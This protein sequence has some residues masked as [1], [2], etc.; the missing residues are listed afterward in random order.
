MNCYPPENT[1]RN[2]Q[3]DWEDH[4]YLPGS[5]D[6]EEIRSRRRRSCLNGDMQSPENMEKSLESIFTEKRDR[7][8]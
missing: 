8:L 5:F 2:R 3:N 1:V 7:C 6:Y 4:L